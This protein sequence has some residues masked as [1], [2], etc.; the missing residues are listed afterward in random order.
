MIKISYQEALSSAPC[1][2]VP[3]HRGCFRI[4]GNFFGARAKVP[5]STVASA[6]AGLALRGS[7]VGWRAEARTLH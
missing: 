1:P 5:G 2:H 3:V 7:A 4:S 6:T